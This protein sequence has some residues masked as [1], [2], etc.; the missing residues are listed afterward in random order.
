MFM[1]SFKLCTRPAY[2]C[3]RPFCVLDRPW[4]Y[5]A[6]DRFYLVCN[7]PLYVRSR[8]VHVCNQSFFCVADRLMYK[9]D[10]L[11]YVEPTVFRA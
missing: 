9:T 11:V 8:P 3:S 7:T 4:L 10:R 1:T 2:L 6:T 5:D